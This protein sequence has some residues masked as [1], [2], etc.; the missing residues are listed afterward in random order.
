MIYF[1]LRV[2]VVP[3]AILGWLGYQTFIKK[4]TWKEIKQDVFATVF[5]IAVW[6]VVY[7]VLLR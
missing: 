7:F 3:I 4:K 5:V 2:L 1:Y 6:I